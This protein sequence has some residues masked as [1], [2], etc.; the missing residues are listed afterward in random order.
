LDL[1][2]SHIDCTFV[3]L[4]Q[5]LVLTNPERPLRKGEEAFFLDNGWEFVTAAQ[6]TTTNDGMPRYCQSSKWLSMNVLSLS[7]TTVVCEEQEHPLHEMLDRLGFEV[8]TVP[9]RHVFEYGGS[10]HC[11]T[12]DVR[13][14]GTGEDYFPR[15]DYVP[16]GGLRR[17]QSR[18]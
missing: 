11:A 7:P 18:V 14:S 5:G 15:Q 8:L 12:W 16:L 3:P 6:P 4:R 17:V 10:L 13:R 1:F 2:P 9:F